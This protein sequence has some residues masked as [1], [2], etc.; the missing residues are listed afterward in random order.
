MEGVHRFFWL[1]HFL[2]YERRSLATVAGARIAPVVGLIV[3]L[4]ASAGIVGLTYYLSPPATGSHGYIW[5]SGGPFVVNWDAGF[6]TGKTANPADSA[7]P[8]WH[9]STHGGGSSNSYISGGVLHVRENDLASTGWDNY[10]NAV[11]QQGN[12]PW[13]DDC[14]HVVG[15]AFPISGFRTFIITCNYSI[16]KAAP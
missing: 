15:S 8:Y 16:H 14:G 11:A 3:T 2:G 13:E 4:V 12:F 9:P 6:R 1:S 10:D 7:A 5:G